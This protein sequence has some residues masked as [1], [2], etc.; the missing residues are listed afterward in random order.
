MG[1]MSYCRF[2]NTSAA[3][4]DCVGALDDAINAPEDCAP[5]S[6][7]EH[8][9]ALRLVE[10][11]SE[12]LQLLADRFGAEVCVIDQAGNQVELDRFNWGDALEEIQQEVID[13]DDRKHASSGSSA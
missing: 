9:A 2:Q 10:Q 12:L 6:S 4:A 1:N 11:A 13:A 5:L 7:D 8:Y 3:L